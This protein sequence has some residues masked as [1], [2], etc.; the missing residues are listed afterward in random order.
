M[1]ERKK[2][3]GVLVVLI[4]LAVCGGH[5]S[6][7]SLGE[8]VE[9]QGFSWLAGRWKTTTDDGTEILLTYRWGLDKHVVF[10]DFK[11]GD[12][13]SHGMIYYVPD[14]DKVVSVG[15]DNKGNISKGAWDIT[16]DKLISKSQYTDSVGQVR[17]IAY[18]IKKVD[19]KTMSL[20]MFTLENG[21]LS[22]Y[23]MWSTE[24]TKQKRTRT[25]ATR[26]KPKK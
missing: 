8:L 4:L 2:M 12:T 14:E 3:R 23:A 10:M 24:F 9:E 21:Q 1:N 26:T 20:E 19:A 22:D 15:L 25:T 13:A 5:V 11:M 6:A 17:D 18:T 7:K 16:D